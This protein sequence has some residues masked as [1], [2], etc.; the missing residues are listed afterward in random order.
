MLVS[1]K[2]KISI[3]TQFHNILIGKLN[4]SQLSVSKRKGTRRCQ[5]RR[6]SRVALSKNT[7]DRQMVSSAPVGGPGVIPPS[8][9]ITPGEPA[10]C[11]MISTSANSSG[12]NSVTSRIR[13]PAN[14]LPAPIPRPNG[15]SRMFRHYVSLIRCSGTRSKRD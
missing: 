12:I 1:L 8:E 10:S 7:I 5:F 14:V 3:K 9:D 2:G 6:S 13:T 11:A 4:V 15:S